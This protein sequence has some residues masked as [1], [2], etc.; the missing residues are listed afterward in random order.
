M[1]ANRKMKDLRY[2]DNG[3]MKMISMVIVLLVAVLVGVMAFFEVTD[4]LDVNEKTTETFTGFASNANA[5]A[6]S[7]TLSYRPASASDI[8]VTCYDST[9]GESYPVFTLDYKTISVAADA[10]KVFTQVNV[11]YT[12]ASASS[13]QKGEDMGV[14]VFNLLPIIALVVVASIILAVVMGFGSG[15]RGGL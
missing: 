4:S 7:V 1:K 15:R 2:N 12:R 13:M 14:T 6:W 11:S 10:A 9:V 8:N 5:S 3:Y